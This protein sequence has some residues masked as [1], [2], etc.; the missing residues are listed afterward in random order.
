MSPEMQT[1]N[2]L[3]ILQFQ[4]Q[5]KMSNCRHIKAIY[6]LIEKFIWIEYLMDDECAIY[7][8]YLFIN[9]LFIYQYWAAP[10]S[11]FPSN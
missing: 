7:L 3:G 8:F 4:R 2:T 10:S 6:G 9:T 5:K 11:G 1:L